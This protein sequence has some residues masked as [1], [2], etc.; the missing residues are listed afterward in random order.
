MKHIVYFTSLPILPARYTHEFI[1]KVFECFI[2]QG[3][4][5]TLSVPDN[6]QELQLSF[7]ETFL[8]PALHEA[9]LTGDVPVRGHERTKDSVL[10]CS[11][12]LDFWR[13]A[14]LYPRHILRMRRLL[15]YQ[16]LESDESF[17]RH[18]SRFRQVILRLIEALTFTMQSVIVVPS[19]AM[20]RIICRR[21]PWLDSNAV[22][23]L[24]NLVEGAYEP[25]ELPHRLWGF[26][27]KPALALG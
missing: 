16:G 19:P 6:P 8:S 25:I 24:P 13:Y 7:I 15:W 26:E 17:Y 10:F 2:S 1:S 14:F 12:T 9:V 20:K 5:V 11:G 3:T 21:H 4:R 22:E 18:R 27:E 23:V